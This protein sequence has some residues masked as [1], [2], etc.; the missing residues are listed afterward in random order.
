MI[1]CKSDSEAF[2]QIEGE[3]VETADKRYTTVTGE[4][5]TILSVRN[6]KREIQGASLND[7]LSV[8]TFWRNQIIPM[9]RAREKG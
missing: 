5:T 6:S 2:T 1:G 7:V 4:G 8:T 9:E 3:K